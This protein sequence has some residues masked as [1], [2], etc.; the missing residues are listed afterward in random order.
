MTFRAKGRCWPAS[1]FT[2]D[3]VIRAA[4]R[5][6]RALAMNLK[7]SRN[8]AAAFFGALLTAGLGWS[9]LTFSFG[10]P[11][12]TKSYELLLVARGE[13]AARDAVIVYLDEISFHK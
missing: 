2:F 8:L 10:R 9:V 7:M 11:V 4:A 3:P 5:V 13:R 1:S 6:A 12:I